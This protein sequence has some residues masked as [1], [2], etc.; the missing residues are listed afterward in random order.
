[1]W[2]AALRQTLTMCL[3]LLLLLQRDGLRLRRPMLLLMM[4][5]MMMTVTGE[6]KSVLT[7]YRNLRLSPSSTPAVKPVFYY[8]PP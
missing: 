6:G 8:N 2:I 4:M 3:R 1:V 5:M 7:I